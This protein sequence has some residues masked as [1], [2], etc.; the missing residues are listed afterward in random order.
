MEGEGGGGDRGEEEEEL[1]LPLSNAPMGD[2]ENE[3]ERRKV[4]LIYHSSTPSREIKDH[5]LTF[6]PLF[7]CFLR[8]VTHCIDGHS[9][10]EDQ[11][12]IQSN[13]QC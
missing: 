10:R 7:E 3:D 13:L 9:N 5:I 6:F 8:E 4:L 11:S 2:G 1:Q 12:K